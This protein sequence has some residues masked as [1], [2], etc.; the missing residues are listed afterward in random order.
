MI[1]VYVAYCG[2]AR[3]ALDMEFLIFK[4]R[5]ISEATS[6]SKTVAKKW[7]GICLVG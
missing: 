7:G 1:L 4:V 5:P 6:L 2:I 3:K